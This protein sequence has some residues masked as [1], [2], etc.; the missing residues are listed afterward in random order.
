MTPTNLKT[1][2]GRAGIIFLGGPIGSPCCYS[3]LVA[4]LVSYILPVDVRVGR[5]WLLHHPAAPDSSWTLQLAG[6]WRAVLDIKPHP[7]WIAALA[8]SRSFF[9]FLWILGHSMALFGVRRGFK[10]LLSHIPLTSLNM[11]S[12]QAIWTHFRPNFIFVCRR[13][14]RSWSKNPRSSWNANLLI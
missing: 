8:N 10:M 9:T 13:N 1:G 4:L 6:A 11:S 14:L 7:G 12:Y 5:Q 3:H 2:W